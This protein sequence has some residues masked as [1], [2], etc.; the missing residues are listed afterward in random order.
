LLTGRY[1]D[2]V[3]VPG[4]IRTHRRNSW[5]YLA[6]DAELLP[7]ALNTV[8]YRTA[9]VGKWHLGLGEPNL[10]NSRGFGFFHGFLGDMM[11]D[12][13][14]HRRHGINYMRRDRTEID[15]PGHATDLFTQWTC[16]W[17]RQHKSDKP[18][19]VYLAYN[20]PHSPIQPPE[21][22]LRRYKARHPGVPE[23]RARLAAL[24]EHTDSGIGKVMEA[25]DQSGHAANT[26]VLFTSDNGGAGY[27]GSDNGPLAGGKQDMLEGGLRVPMCAVWP[28]RIER[29]SVSDRVALT[30]DLFPTI[31]EAAGAKIDHPIDGRSVLPA[32][33]GKPQPPED[34]YLFW[35]RL[36]GGRRYQGKPYYGARHGDW[37][38][39]QNDATEPYRLYNLADDPAETTDVSARHPAVFTDLKKALDAHIARCARIPWR[40][41]EGAGPGEI[42]E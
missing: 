20:A 15:P 7:A 11:D 22:N 3:G 19:F 33:L 17:L 12:Y 8:G 9:M 6:P 14:H 27:F 24:V 38:L 18:F 34:R 21:E 39:L 31:C 42:G 40:D 25:L 36:E 1:P 26:L 30:M 41:P 37:K 10:P 32:L 35:V 13:Y 4:V 23:K 5:G 2:A 16:E 28:E 29:G